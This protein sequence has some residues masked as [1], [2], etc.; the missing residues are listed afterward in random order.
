M[1]PRR[2]VPGLV[3]SRVS[4]RGAHPAHRGAHPAW[5]RRCGGVWRG[6]LVSRSRPVQ[7]NMVPHGPTGSHSIALTELLSSPLPGGAL[8]RHRRAEGVGSG[9]GGVRCQSASA[10]GMS[11]VSSL[12]R[13]VCRAAASVRG[14]VSRS[15]ARACRARTPCATGAREVLA[16]FTAGKPRLGC[17]SLCPKLFPRQALRP[18]RSVAAGRAQHPRLCRK[19]GLQARPV[20]QARPV[21]QA[22][23]A[24]WAHPARA[25]KARRAYPARRAHPAC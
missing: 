3:Q 22:H 15:A 13:A 21:H 5:I 24:R 10:G 18:L 11:T 7:F 20:R 14:A 9:S 2:R 25:R 16:A 19:P 12:A 23:L 1:C 4:G 17:Q 8:K 6:V